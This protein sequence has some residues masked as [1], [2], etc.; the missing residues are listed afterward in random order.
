MKKKRI[1][2]ADDS[3]TTIMLLKEILISNGYD[4][5][6]AKDGI[7]ASILS[8]KEIPDLIISDIEMP[9]MDG[10]QVCRLLKNDDEMKKI[11]FIILTSKEGIGAEFWGYQT[12][13]DLYILKNFEEKHL[14]NSIKDLLKKYSDTKP[15]HSKIQRNITYD[16]IMQKTN[17]FLDNQLFEMT[18]INEI[19]KISN[20]QSSISDTL[21]EIIEVLKKTID[22]Q[23]LSFSIITDEKK[24]LLLLYQFLNIDEETLQLFEFNCLEDLSVSLNKDI[25]EYTIEVE[26]IEDSNIKKHKK[27]KNYNRN[28]LYSLTLKIKNEIIGIIHIYNE[29]MN[30]IPTEQKT[31][32]SK[33]SSHISSALN[34]SIL[35]NRIKELSVID[36]LTQVY[37][38]RYIMEIFKIEFEKSIRYDR[39]LSIIMIDIDDFKKVNDDYGHLTG[40]IVLKKTAEI[41]KKTIRNVDIPGRYGGEEFIIILPETEKNS[42]V[43]IAE[44]IRK[45]IMETRFK[46]FINRDITITI[47]LGV[48]CI[49]ELDIKEN[50]MEIIKLADKRLYKAKLSGK[51]KVVYE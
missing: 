42:G 2:I 20:K 37:N 34:A 30:K 19:N 10:Y 29:L 13:T 9:R 45:N 33:L 21:I 6:T 44:R 48:S 7:E 28:N 35:H 18:L 40:D 46:S 8:Y 47:S 43:K 49:S 14:I 26:V 50:E 38:R 1:L 11:P 32:L 16:N 41:C 36:G 31:L 15:D 5:I 24:V 22:F 25:S 27:I 3:P 23:I 4:V 39:T 12:G 51:N 17:K